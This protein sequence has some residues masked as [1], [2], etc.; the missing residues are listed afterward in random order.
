MATMALKHKANTPMNR[1]W[2]A[3][4]TRTESEEDKD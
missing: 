2:R 4:M 1:R 3:R